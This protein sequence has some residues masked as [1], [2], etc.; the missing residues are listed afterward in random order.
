MRTEARILAYPA[1]F[2]P[3]DEGDRA[4]SSPRIEVEIIEE[5]GGG[6]GAEIAMILRS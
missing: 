4:H 2:V 6:H 5:C 1:T 3:P